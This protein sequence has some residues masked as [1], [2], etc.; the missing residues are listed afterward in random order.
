MS[1][2]KSSTVAILSAWVA[3][4]AAARAE[5]FGLE[6]LDLRQVEQGWGEPHANMSVDNHSLLLDGKRFQHGLGTHANSTWRIALNGTAERFT[7][8]V[9]VDDEVGQKGSV[10][11]RVSGDGRKLW[12]SGVLRGGGHPQQVS[13]D[14]RG[15][16]SLL[17]TVTDAGDGIDFDHA[18]WADAQITMSQ[19]KPLA[20]AFPREPAV[21]LTPK[22][23]P[24]PRLNGAKVFGV[25][26]GSP[27]L[28]TIPATGRAAYGL[29]RRTSPGRTGTRH[30]DRPPHRRTCK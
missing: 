12:E 29:L 30:P 13:V 8:T 19:G 2:M 24:K 28:F 26:P 1:S 23:S 22:P 7:A 18:D 9:G 21:V 17:L 16:K 3:L 11:F 20:V 5:T 25:R 10:T 14:L 4:A 15:V 6:T 27:V